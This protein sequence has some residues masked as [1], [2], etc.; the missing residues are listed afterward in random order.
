MTGREEQGLDEFVEEAIRSTNPWD[1]VVSIVEAAPVSGRDTVVAALCK[2]L[3]SSP[4]PLDVLHAVRHTDWLVKDEGFVRTAV[5]R[6]NDIAAALRQSPNPDYDLHRLLAVPQLLKEGDIRR[7]VADLVRAHKTPCYV[8]RQLKEHSAVWEHHEVVDALRARSADIATALSDPQLAGRVV[9]EICG[10]PVVEFP[11][12]R[13]AVCRQLR[14]SG[15]YMLVGAVMRCEDFRDSPDIRQSIVSAMETLKDPWWLVDAARE[16]G[17]L[18]DPEV[19]AAV[20]RRIAEEFVTAGPDTDLSA[21][22][23]ALEDTP[24][25]CNDEDVAG[26]IADAISRADDPV[27]VMAFLLRVP[28]LHN[29]RR[30]IE[31][32]R[33]LI[34][35]SKSLGLVLYKIAQYAPALLREPT[36]H[37]AI[38]S[39]AMRDPEPWSV[40]DG[41]DSIEGASG[42]PAVWQ[43]I[44]EGLVEA[45][46]RM[47]E[48]A[49]RPEEMIDQI[50]SHYRWLLDDP[51]MMTAIESRTDYFASLVRECGRDL[52]ALHTLSVCAP[53]VLAEPP[54]RKAL[55]A[56]MRGHPDPISVLWYTAYARGADND[57]EIAESTV[58]RAPDIVRD[59]TPRRACDVVIAL[60]EVMPSLLDDMGVVRAV[61]RAVS[62][63]PKPW[64]VLFCLKQHAP[65]LYEDE[66][67]RAAAIGR[68]DDIALALS[69]STEQWT[70][71]RGVVDIAEIIRDERVKWGLRRR[72]AR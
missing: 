12:V 64:E 49:P 61:A 52:S 57:R 32:V 15:H 45:A 34:T 2:V 60:A 20:A 41:L 72:W 68:I 24:E 7:A 35:E 47:M 65:R 53:W 21:A 31:A 16:H 22:V 67:V 19:R 36:I 29:K 59:M 58:M 38:V 40:L 51:R 1:A 26:A 3:A 4:V 46:A 25:V 6:S 66:S 44:R 71:L 42:D 54:V 23:M 14:E 56:L 50:W 10:T 48:T 69:Q 5:S 30:F 37:S 33:D 9:E 43:P 39:A 17:L 27:L 11:E 13:G 8:A 55:A 63:H 70:I 62:E 28:A 18:S